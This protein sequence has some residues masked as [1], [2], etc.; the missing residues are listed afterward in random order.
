MFQ[1]KL[2]T[3]KKKIEIVKYCILKDFNYIDTSKRYGIKPQIIR[4]WISIYERK[5][6]EGLIFKVNSK[7]EEDIIKELRTLRTEHWKELCENHKLKEEL[8]ELKSI[9][10]GNI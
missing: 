1:F 6:A 9:I 8:E 7:S 5:G 4:E 2:F 3:F 10:E